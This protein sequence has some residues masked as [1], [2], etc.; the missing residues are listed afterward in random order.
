MSNGNFINFHWVECKNLAS[1]GNMPIK[2]QLDKSPT[3]VVLGKNG[4]GK[5]SLILDSVCFALFGKPFRNINKGQLVNN[6]NNKDMLVSVS[7]TR[8]NDNIIVKRGIKPNIFE[9]FINDKMIDQAS[10]IRDYQKYF[11]EQIL[12]ID[13]VSFTQIVM[14]GKANYIPFMSLN[15]AQKR[16]FVERILGLDVF[17]QMSLIHKSNA[18]AH[19]ERLTSLKNNIRITGEKL[20]AQTKLV[21]HI[22]ATARQ[23]EED[24]RNN[25]LSQIETLNAERDNYSVQQEEL[26]RELFKINIK[27]IQDA[28]SKSQDLQ[29]RMKNLV[30]A[31][32]NND[33]NTVRDIR[34]FET[35]D[36]CPTCSQS[37]SPEFKASSLDTKQRKH[38]QFETSI[39]ELDKKIEDEIAKAASLAKQRDTAKAIMTKINS[40]GEKINDVNNKIINLTSSLKSVKIDSSSLD[41][42]M[43]ELALIKDTLQQYYTDYNTAVEETNYLNFMSVCLKDSGIKSTIIKEYLPVI[44]ATVNQNLKQLGLFA[45]IVI[46]EQFKEEIRMRG[47]ETMSYFQLS[48]GEKLRIDMAIMMSWRDVAKYKANMSCNLL[49][50]DEIFD[51]SVDADGT[52]A[53]ADLLKTVSNLNVFVITHTPE[54]LAD[55]F[56]S[57]IRLEKKDG[58]TTLANQGNY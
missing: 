14:I 43:S 23:T 57:F 4:S 30:A 49:I 22:E 53:F 28:L 26:K 46:D 12:G 7:F 48:E 32:R 17:S 2:I 9:I 50:M 39:T 29:D 40:V 3:T 44:N 1:V 36:I 10:K 25:I 51:S 37:I 33:N 52:A 11:E 15:P 45:N 31:I 5:S 18:D 38:A 58:F 13:Y 24:S 16:Q 47:F 21:E 42:E 56:K 54:K 41:K 35:N 8:G 27:D 34:F 6:K 19:N 20:K 55:S